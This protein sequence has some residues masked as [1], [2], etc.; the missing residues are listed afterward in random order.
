MEFIVLAVYLLLELIK[1]LIIIEIVLSWVSLLGLHIAIPFISLVVHPLFDRVRKIIPSTFSGMD[2]A[3]LYVLLAI[4]IFQ[5]TAIQYI[6][7]LL[8]SL[9]SFL[10]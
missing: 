8:Y 2:F 7:G 9:P 1:W 3:P 10:R 6:P 4:Y 5:N